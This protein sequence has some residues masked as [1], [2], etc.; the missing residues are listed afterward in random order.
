MQ[1]YP[2]HGHSSDYTASELAEMLVDPYDEAPKCKSLVS[3]LL[4]P[5][6]PDPMSSLTLVRSTHTQTPKES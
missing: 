4:P 6:L 5:L 3:F 1:L 2:R